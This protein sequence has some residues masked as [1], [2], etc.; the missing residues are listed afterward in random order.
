MFRILRPVSPRVGHLSSEFG[1]YCE[2]VFLVPKSLNVSLSPNVMG[3]NRELLAGADSSFDARRMA[4]SLIRKFSASIVPLPGRGPALAQ[5]RLM[6][7]RGGWLRVMR[8]P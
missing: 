6:G 4:S 1:V 2:I 5:S 3:T 8:W 7:S